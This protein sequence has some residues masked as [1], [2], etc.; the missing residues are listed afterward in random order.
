MLYRGL[1]REWVG[2]RF[3]L[4][5]N[6]VNTSKKQMVPEICRR[7]ELYYA[8]LKCQQNIVEQ[9]KIDFQNAKQCYDVTRELMYMI[10]NL[11]W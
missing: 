8:K 5:V 4:A 6:T 1:Y 7:T 3:N 2:N 9:D 11:K 10:P